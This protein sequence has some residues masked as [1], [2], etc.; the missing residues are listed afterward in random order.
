MNKVGRVVMIIVLIAIL[1]GAVCVG[2]GMMT[3]GEWDRI[4]SELDD[5][6]HL[7]AYV[8]YVRV[9]LVNFFKEAWAAVNAPAA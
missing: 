7:D 2:V 5:A 6:Y 4:Y 9:D 8:H 1:A 3:G